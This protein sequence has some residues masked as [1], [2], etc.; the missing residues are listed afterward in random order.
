MKTVT[1][2][3]KPASWH[4]TRQR[5]PRC[6]RVYSLHERLLGYI[7]IMEQKMETTIMDHIGVIHRHGAEPHETWSSTGLSW[8]LLG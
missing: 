2:P 1:I 7:G 3:A 6:S 5:M 4:H 8:Q